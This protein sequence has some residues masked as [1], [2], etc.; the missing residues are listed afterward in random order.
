M[1]YWFSA[2]TVSGRPAGSGASTIRVCWSFAYYN[3]LEHRKRAVDIDMA[4]AGTE[5]VDESRFLIPLSA[6]PSCTV[7]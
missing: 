2:L 7:S 6:V 4:F 3:T 1:Q 5:E